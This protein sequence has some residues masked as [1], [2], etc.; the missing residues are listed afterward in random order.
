MSRTYERLTIEDFGAHLLNTADLDPIYLALRAMGMPEAQLNRWL[1][2][3]WCCYHAGAASYLSEFEG[4]EFFEM[5][6]HAAENVRAAPT[7]DRWPRGGERRHWRGMQATSCV[8]YLIDRYGEKP[9]DMAA[10]C[11]GNGGTFQEVSKRAQEHR[12]FGPWIGFKVA[13]MVDRVLG[14]TVTF[15][16]A[17]VF[18]FK[19]PYKAA[20]IQYETNLNIPEHVLGDGSVAPRNRELVTPDTVNH[21]AACLIQHFSD[22][23]APPHRDRPVNIQEVET[24]L[25]KW[26]SHMN[27]HYPL[28]NDIKEIV[29]GAHPWVKHSKTAE[30]F[31]SSMPTL[32]K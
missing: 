15:D 4:K 8:E 9:E 3:Y 7:G 25:C 1:L 22:H 31:V 12:L 21:V 29:E 11:A 5:L 16:N 10:Y 27:G 24:I 19:D 18:M 6:N 30:L 28:F 32:E 2:A 14:K 20:T 23:L 17:A 26:K 13:D